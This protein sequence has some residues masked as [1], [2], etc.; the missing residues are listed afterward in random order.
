[1]I[2]RDASIDVYVVVGEKGVLAHMMT[3]PVIQS[4]RTQNFPV[5]KTAPYRPVIVMQ[6]SPPICIAQSWQSRSWYIP[7]HAALRN[8]PHMPC[9]V[10]TGLHGASYTKTNQTTVSRPRLDLLQASAGIQRLEL[11][12]PVV[13]P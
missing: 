10:R 4:S 5:I 9:C 8:L 1:M 12:L 3:I 6:W 11:S 2:L 13:P 7:K